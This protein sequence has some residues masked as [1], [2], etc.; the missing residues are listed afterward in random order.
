[1]VKYLYYQDQ[2]SSDHMHPAMLEIGLKLITD[3]LVGTNQTTLAILVAI[4]EVVN[5]F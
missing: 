5:S 1:M 2:P 3:K 4:K